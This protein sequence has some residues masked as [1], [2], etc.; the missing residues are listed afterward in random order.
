M[1]IYNKKLQNKIGINFDDYKKESRKLKIGEKNGKGKEYILNTNILIFEGE[2][3]NGR[4]NGKGKIYYDD[5]SIKFEGE[6]FKGKIIEGKGNDNQGN[7]ILKIER[8][9]KGKEYY[10]N[11]KIQFEGEYYNGR[12]WSGKGYN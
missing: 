4:K 8:N 10:N 1:I 11:G 3:L 6:Y 9:G 2:Y 5:E 7:E 12:R